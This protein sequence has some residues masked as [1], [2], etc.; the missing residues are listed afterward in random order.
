MSAAVAAPLLYSRLLLF[1][2]LCLGLPALQ[3][4][5]AQEQGKYHQEQR[6]P[7]ALPNGGP[8]S[9]ASSYAATHE[10]II[11]PGGNRVYPH[12]AYPG[13]IPGWR[14]QVGL[15]NLALPAPALMVLCAGRRPILKPVRVTIQSRGAMPVAGI[16]CLLVSAAGVVWDPTSSG[17][18]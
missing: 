4:S 2:F 13:R 3:Q 10:N 1:L 12:P 15:R 6:A 18:S 5:K 11:R 9:A 8:P 7:S 14:V 16:S 17:S